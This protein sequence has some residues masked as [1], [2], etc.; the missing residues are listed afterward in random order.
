MQIA[1]YTWVA[2]FFAVV[3][4]LALQHS[5]GPIASVMR[6]RWLRELGAVSYCVYVIHL[7]V[8][9]VC[10]RVLLH[11]DPTIATPK[12]VVVTVFAGLLTFALAKVSWVVFE[13]P[14]LRL[15][16]KYKYAAKENKDRVPVA[17]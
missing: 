13:G 15:G 14:L 5:S 2:L 8:N 12:G 10:H 16:H 6:M 11:G 3:L 1:G 9:L 7:V 4:L 17:A